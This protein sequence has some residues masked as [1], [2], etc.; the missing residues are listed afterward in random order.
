M[1][2]SPNLTDSTETRGFL[3]R[4][5][6]A[7]SP[8][9]L[10]Q[11]NPID[12]TIQPQV[13]AFGAVPAVA[14]AVSPKSPALT[15]ELRSRR[16]QY[17]PKT[18]NVAPDRQETG[19]FFRDADGPA[20]S[21][22]TCRQKSH[23]RPAPSPAQPPWPCRLSGSAA[24]Y[25]QPTTLRWPLLPPADPVC[26]CSSTNQSSCRPRILTPFTSSFS[27]SP[28]PVSTADCSSLAIASS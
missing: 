11:G 8:L 20:L 17:S 5:Q 25:A 28:S 27:T 3:S 24:I 22:I 16:R 12:A 10:C 19:R 15:V 18:V 2:R 1:Q 13:P 23:F 9:N 6:A 4:Q 7:F 21:R 14:Q 26:V